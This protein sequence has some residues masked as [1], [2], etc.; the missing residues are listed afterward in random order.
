MVESGKPAWDLVDHVPTLGIFDRK[1][2]VDIST[3]QVKPMQWRRLQHVKFL[4]AD[5]RLAKHSGQP[6]GRLNKKD[7][8]NRYGNS[9]VKDKTS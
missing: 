1:V 5:G 9:H 8:L 4:W 7:G 2:M 3:G 6:G